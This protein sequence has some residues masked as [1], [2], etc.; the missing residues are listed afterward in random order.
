MKR[1]STILLAGMVVLMS[2]VALLSSRSGPSVS[3]GE[4]SG[5]NGLGLD[6][7]TILWIRVQRDYWNTFTLSREGTGQWRL[8]EPSEEPASQPAVTSLFHS[9]TRFPVTSRINLPA[10]DSERYREYGLWEPT[11]QITIGTVDGPLLLQLGSETSDGKGVYC[12]IEGDDGVLVTPLQ[13]AAL[14]RRE[15]DAYRAGPSDALSSAAPARGRVQIEDIRVG[16]GGMVA[17][18]QRLSV[19]YTGRLLDG[20]EFDNSRT[21]GTP[22]SFVLG[23]GEVILGWEQGLSGMRVG[24]TRTLTIPPELGYGA[25]GKPPTIP[26]QATLVFDIELLA[27]D[28]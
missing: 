11:V 23:A 28:G 27:A 19:H 3:P 22:F 14:L 24:G 1:H 5:E 13:N 18:G 9:L 10:D 21:R 6:P 7:D 15:I 25:E 26:Q 20:T 17:P 8:I 12:I 4:R 16:T 2:V